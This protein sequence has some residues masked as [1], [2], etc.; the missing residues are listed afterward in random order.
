M[1]RR[2]KLPVGPPPH[3]TAGETHAM[4]VIAFK[5]G[6]KRVVVTLQPVTSALEGLVFQIEREYPINP[7]GLVGQLLK[8]LRT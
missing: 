7:L 2:K 8:A 6:T 1:P 5:L 4:R 3:V